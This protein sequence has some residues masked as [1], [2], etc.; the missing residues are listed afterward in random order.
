[1]AGTV[2]IP[3]STLAVGTHVFGPAAV[4]DAD[5]QALL[6]IDRTVTGG[7]N[8]LTPATGIQII[9]DQ[10][11]D[12]GA[13]WTQICSA[14]VTGGFT[15]SANHPV[16]P[17]TSSVGATFQP[18]TSRQARAQVTVTGTSVAVQGTLVTS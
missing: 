15:T 8:S 1:M 4:A 13:T 11:N 7:L 9:V 2:N 10:S 3:L 17:G 5:K 16:P 18:G 14:P 12:G 6:T